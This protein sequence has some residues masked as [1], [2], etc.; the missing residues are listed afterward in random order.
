MKIHILFP[1][2]SGPWGGGNQFL[3]A[4]RAYFQKR[5]VYSDDPDKAD[6]ILFNSHHQLLE[7]AKLKRKRQSAVFVH[8]VDGPVFLIRGRD[9]EIDSLIFR[10]NEAMA[11]GTIFQSGWSRDKCREQGLKIHTKNTLIYNAPDPSIFFPPLNRKSIGVSKIRIV[12]TSWSANKRKGFDIY[13]YLDRNL[14]FDRYSFTFVGQ[15]NIDF[16]NIARMHPQPSA[17]LA[18]ILRNHDIFLTASLDDPCSNSLLEGLH[19]GLP[20]VGRNSGGHP[21]LIKGQGRIFNSESDVLEA[22]DDVANRLEEYRMK[23]CPSTM[24]ET[25]NSYLTFCE[26]I[27]ISGKEQRKR[28][29]TLT[30]LGVLALIMKEKK[31]PFFQRFRAKQT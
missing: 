28:F 19:C 18:N 1:F 3:K 8:R 7:A 9:R 30:Y 25:G 6:V 26:S 5:N 11:D 13:E 10:F 17:D 2:Q 14:D 4:L 29:T 27:Y 21:E 15:S 12:A 24:D 20:A 16:K 31:L 22:I 23:L